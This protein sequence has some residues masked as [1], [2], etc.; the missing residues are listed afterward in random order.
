[1]KRLLISPHDDD[2]ALFGAVTCLRYHPDVLIVLDSYIQTNRGE[3]VDAAG[4]E[5]E[6]EEA[7]KILGC[8][9]L[10]SH[11][12][13]DTVTEQEIENS[14]QVYAT[15]GYDLVYVPE[16]QG[17]NIH[18]DMVN[19]VAKRVFGDKCIFYTTYTKQ[20]LWTTGE[21]EAVPNERELQLKNEALDCYKSQ[22]AIN[23]PHF[24][25]IYGKSE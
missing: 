20:D 10:R 18:H 17:G 13:D 8:R 1:M 24:Q 23:L 12:R 11:L 9:T 4:R 6:T 22:I 14:L 2:Q 3:R 21:T 15:Y 7:N 16:L 19:R 5:K 25:A